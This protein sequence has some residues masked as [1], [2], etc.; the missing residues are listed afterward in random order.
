MRVG[1][2]GAYLLGVFKMIGEE[3]DVEAIKDEEGFERRLRVQ[4]IVYLLQGHPEFRRYLNFHFS[5]Y[6]YGP[7]SPELAFVYY[8]ELDGI[9]PAEVA[10]SKEALD[11]AAEI[12]SMSTK[13][14]E[15]L[16]TLAETIKVNR[17]RVE[18]EGI[19]WIVHELKPIF[20]REEIAE[21]L[22]RLRYLKRRYGL[23]W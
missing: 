17:G 15:I 14:L 3:L 21:L 13:D 23:S 20:S 1:K 7:Y 12:T 22:E 2:R 11:Y 4:K 5:M 10:L 16:A 6:F 19:I 18:D 8:N 9:T